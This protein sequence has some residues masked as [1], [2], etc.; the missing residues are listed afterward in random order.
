M[1]T[2]VRFLDLSG[3]EDEIRAGRG[4]KILVHGDQRQYIQVFVVDR[5]TFE[6]AQTPQIGGQPDAD[7]N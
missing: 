1:N 6:N 5:S 7:D 4:L 2:I 3:L